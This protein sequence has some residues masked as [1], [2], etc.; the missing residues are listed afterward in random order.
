M[1]KFASGFL[2]FLKYGFKKRRPFTDRTGRHFA[3]FVLFGG[4]HSIAFLPF[5]LHPGCPTVIRRHADTPAGA[6]VVR[7]KWPC[8]RMRSAVWSSAAVSTSQY[9]VTAPL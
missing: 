2:G 7:R 3:T 5:E 6:P 1:P 8:V 9:R 4:A